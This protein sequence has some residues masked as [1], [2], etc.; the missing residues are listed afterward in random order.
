M[1]RQQHRRRRK[2][3]GRRKMDGGG[4]AS[5]EALRQREAG[6][7]EQ[8][9]TGLQ[10]VARRVVHRSVAIAVFLVEVVRP[11]L[12]EEA[13]ERLGVL[14]NAMAS[15]FD[16][17]VAGEVE[18]GHALVLADRV[19]IRAVRLEYS[20]DQYRLRA[21]DGQ[22]PGAALV[23]EVGHAQLG[24]VVARRA[25]RQCIAP[26]RRRVP[27]AAA[28]QQQEQGEACCHIV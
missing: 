11:F 26:A 6:G 8:L 3:W 18:Q 23:V 15:T 17:A 4:G 28:A 2:A 19:R 10:S 25:P 7:A 12:E 1:A 21:A 14:K 16:G 27:G 13:H 24:Q 22:A 5:A 20:F 9:D